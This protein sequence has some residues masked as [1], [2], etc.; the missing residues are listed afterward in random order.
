MFQRD[1]HPGKGQRQLSFFYQVEFRA[2]VAYWTG[3]FPFEHQ[4]PIVGF[5]HKAAKCEDA[6]TNLSQLKFKSEASLELVKEVLALTIPFRWIAPQV[7]LLSE[8]LEFV[9]KIWITLWRV[10]I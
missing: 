4:H 1:T 10:T 6:L 2:Q 8:D 3:Q 9:E 5:A 7:L